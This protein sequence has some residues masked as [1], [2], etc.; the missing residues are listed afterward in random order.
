MSPTIRPNSGNENPVAI[1]DPE[2]IAKELADLNTLVSQI[3]SEVST[4]SVK[5]ENISTAV[6]NAGAKVDDVLR[7]NI[8]IGKTVQGI[9][10]TTDNHNAKQQ[11]FEQLLLGLNS[12]IEAAQQFLSEVQLKQNTNINH[13]ETL[14][15]DKEK[16]RSEMQQHAN[17]ITEYVNKM[18]TIS[19]DIDTLKT[20]NS[21]AENLIQTNVKVCIG[22][23]C[24][25]VLISIFQMLDVFGLIGKLFKML[26]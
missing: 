12:S 11:E 4:L 6:D 9:K 7:T 19:E 13:I 17:R 18:R 21:N 10:G 26:F 15:R 24:L 8:A 16:I 20:C 14:S 2:S 5:I 1:K 22:G 3:R 25:I 23:T